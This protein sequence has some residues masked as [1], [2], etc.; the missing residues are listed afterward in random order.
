MEVNPVAICLQLTSPIP[1]TPYGTFACSSLLRYM[2]LLKGKH[3]MSCS[4]TFG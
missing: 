4:Y 2:N 3:L 1:P